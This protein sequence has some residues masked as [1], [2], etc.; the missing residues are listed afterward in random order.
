MRCK[1]CG[2]ENQDWNPTQSPEMK[3]FCI[4]CGA[5]LELQDAQQNTAAEPA[6]SPRKQR[7]VP[8][9]AFGGT[10]EAAAALTPSADD[11]APEGP[12]QSGMQNAAG[13]QPDAGQAGRP[14]SGAQNAAGQQSA[15]VPRQEASAAPKAPPAEA[16]KVPPAET[17]ASAP[18]TGKPKKRIGLRI[19]I[20]A[21]ALVAALAVCFFTVHA[22]EPATCTEPETCKICGRTRGEAIGHDW[23]EA[24][25]TEPPT[26]T[27][28]GEH[29]GVARGHS[30]SPATCTKAAVCSRCGETEGSPLGHNWREATATT[31]MTCTRCGETQGNPL[32]NVGYVSGDYSEKS[33]DV[34][35]NETYPYMF[36]TTGRTWRH[37]TV[38]VVI[39]ETTG[40]IYGKHAIYVYT[41]GKG[42]WSAET[43]QFEAG[44]VGRTLTFEL[45]F[46]EGAQIDGVAEVCRVTGGGEWS[47]RFTITVTN[48]VTM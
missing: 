40:S 25:C 16:P 10:L 36:S 19:G 32:V 3:R 45:D 8:N 4:S 15:F 17:P 5:E 42:W 7:S 38:T 2:A 11:P 21:A 44:D 43:F 30:F 31:P 24:T 47:A 20:A 18:E 48:G 46:P 27:V 23:M 22:W 33:V 1:A 34:A 35:E 41:P 9:A 13:Q 26:C 6:P 14:Q 37:L 29:Q 28:C 12:Q 39:T